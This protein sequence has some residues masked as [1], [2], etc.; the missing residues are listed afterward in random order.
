MTLKNRADFSSFL[1][2][3][4][5]VVAE[6]YLEVCPENRTA[7]EGFIR[8]GRIVLG[9]WYVL[10]D[11]F[12]PSGESLIRNLLLGRKQMADLGAPTGAIGYLPRHFRPPCPNCP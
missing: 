10:P 12:I 2:D 11:E 6:D 9:P 7:L 3:G 5:T 8:S 4:Q 1:L